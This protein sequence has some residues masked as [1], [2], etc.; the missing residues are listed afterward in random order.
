[1]TTPF[2]SGYS[3]VKR[4]KVAVEY[5]AV[6]MPSTISSRKLKTISNIV[7]IKDTNLWE[8]I[9]ITIQQLE[10]RGK[11]RAKRRKAV[12]HEEKIR[13]LTDDIVAGNRIVILSSISFSVVSFDYIR[14][15]IQLTL[16]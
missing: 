11:L 4:V 1:M 14:E 13:R 7:G 6:P 9:E 12:Q 15:S 3:W 10:G 5:M 8:I 2:L 16:N